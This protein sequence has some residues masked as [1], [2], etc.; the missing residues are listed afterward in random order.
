MDYNQVLKDHKKIRD[1]KIKKRKSKKR[2]KSECRI[3]VSPFLISIL[4][5]FKLDPMLTE[6]ILIYFYN[7]TASFQ[8]FI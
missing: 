1:E 3:K 5:L 2:V 7:Y 6:Y 4:L 8:D